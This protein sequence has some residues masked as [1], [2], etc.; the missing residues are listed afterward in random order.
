MEKRPVRLTLRN[1]HVAKLVETEVGG[2]V[3]YAFGTP[4]AI[5]G[6]VSLDLQQSGEAT[7]FYA[8]GLLYYSDFSNNGYTGS[9]EV[10]K[11]PKQMFEKIW[12]ETEGAASHVLSE[13]ANV[14]PAHFA[15]LFEIAENVGDDRF[16]FY[17]CVAS[18][19]NSGANTK[20]A[21]NDPQTQSC[22]L[23]IIPLDNG[24]VKARTTE[25]TPASVKSGWFSAVFMETGV[26]AYVV[27]YNANGGTGSVVDGNSPYASGAT[28]KA[29]HADGLTAP[30]SKSFSE[31]NTKP[32]GSGDDY[33]P[34]DDITVNANVTLYAIWA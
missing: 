10:A 4:F 15:L 3:Q 22:E 6:A 33:D 7:S 1:V 32:D 2:V 16:A 18:R 24:L 9:L 13:N 21:A 34:G 29:M 31:W 20:E 11:F 8:D 5:P 14:Q 30:A 17:N 27:E 28:A 23:T 19:P 12:K 26:G 25:D